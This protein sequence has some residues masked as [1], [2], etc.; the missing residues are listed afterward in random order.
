MFDLERFV[1]AQSPVL[2]AV[3]AELRAGRKETHWIW[4]IFPQLTALGHSATARHFGISGLAEAEAYLAHPTLGPRLIECTQLVT[5]LNDRSAEEIFPYPDHLK[6]RSCLTLFAT[7]APD[8][9]AFREAL[10]IFFA[11]QPDPET[12]ALLRQS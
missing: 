11:G 9:P 6:F 5:D 12:L 1:A 4:F 10:E 2:A 8:A 7:A 3:L